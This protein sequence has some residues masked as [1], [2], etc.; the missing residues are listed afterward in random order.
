M[1]GD[2]D[3]IQHATATLMATCTFVISTS[4]TDSGTGTTTGST[5]TGTATTPRLCSQLPPLLSSPRV[6]GVLL[7]EVAVPAPEHTSYLLN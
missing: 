4:T 2:T 6:G 7:L 1:G 5:M 3:G